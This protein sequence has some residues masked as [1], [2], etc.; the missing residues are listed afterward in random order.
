M[1]FLFDEFKHGIMVSDTKQFQLVSDISTEF[2]WVRNARA[3]TI[4]ANK[5][6]A[7]SMINKAKFISANSF[8]HPVR[9]EEMCNWP[10]SK[11]VR[12]KKGQGENGELLNILE[13]FAHFKKGDQLID[14]DTIDVLLHCFAAEISYMCFYFSA[15]LLLKKIKQQGYT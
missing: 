6:F 5:L 10:G 12:D 4:L 14:I 3:A 1:E 11:L 13:N 8:H 15:R 2:P 7:Y 9:D